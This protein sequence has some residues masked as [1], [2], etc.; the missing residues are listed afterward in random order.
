MREA[1]ASLKSSVVAILQRPGI[2]VWTPAI[3]QGSQNWM[4][5]SGA[6]WYKGWQY[7]V[8]KEKVG[9]D[10][11]KAAKAVTR[12]IQTAEIFDIA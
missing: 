7:S 9:A 2:K 1:L 5:D 8:T 3:R 12:K 11:I 4:G 6:P 10:T